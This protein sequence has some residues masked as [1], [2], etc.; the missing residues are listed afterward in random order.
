MFE[1]KPCFLDHPSETEESDLPERTVR[2]QV[3][4]YKNLR[5]EKL[6][7]PQTGP[8]GRRL[9]RR[10]ALRP[11]RG[12]ARGVRQGP[13]GS[14]LSAGLPR[15]P[16]AVRR[17]VRPRRRQGRDAHD[18]GG[19]RRRRGPLRDR[20]HRGRLVRH[21]D[22]RRPRRPRPRRHFRERS[23]RT[24]GR[25]EE[26]EGDAGQ[27]PG[28][29]QEGDG[30]GEGR[31]RHR[32]QAAQDRHPGHRGRRGRRGRRHG[33]RG[34]LRQA[35]G[36]VRRGP[37]GP[38]A[39]ARQAPVRPARRQGRGR[40]RR[41]RRR[42]RGGGQARPKAQEADREARVY[43]VKAYIAEAGV[44][45]DVYDEAELAALAKMPFREAKRA[46]DKDARLVESATKK[47]LQA[48]FPSRSCA[49][50]TARA[51][52]R[53]RRVAATPLSKSRFGRRTNP[54]RTA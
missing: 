34:R 10:A 22:A 51:P 38:H 43:A 5:V 42:G 31:A 33:R 4:F 35:R 40:G 46:I 13:D 53:T 44:D 23:R 6:K 54:W 11:V 25:H 50:A 16:P 49:P 30:R 47:L 41:G 9:R 26:T 3:G 20:V 28:V 48:A 1:G 32:D 12:R 17:L 52:R 37:Q 29:G 19:R 21:G 15:L 36:R 24:G 39:Q 45:E 2:R 18:G 27:A 14:P 7:Q 8:H